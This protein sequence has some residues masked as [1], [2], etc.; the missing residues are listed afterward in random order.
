MQGGDRGSAP[1]YSV[2]RGANHAGLHFDS[3]YPC[4][5]GSLNSM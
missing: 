1:D 4:A 5:C 2:N 3:L